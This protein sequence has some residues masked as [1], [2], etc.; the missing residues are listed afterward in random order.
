MGV[1]FNALIQPYVECGGINTWI[2]SIENV[3]IGSGQIVESVA[4]F[5]NASYLMNIIR[6][7]NYDFKQN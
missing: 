7:I 5:R 6:I 1:L 3:I 2:N 4:E